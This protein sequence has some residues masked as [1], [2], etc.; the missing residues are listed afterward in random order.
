MSTALVCANVAAAPVAQSVEQRTFNPRARRSKLRGGT[1]EP[2]ITALADAR[3][4][5]AEKLAA[6]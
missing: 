3:H 1:N 5:L 4:A 2:V 6:A